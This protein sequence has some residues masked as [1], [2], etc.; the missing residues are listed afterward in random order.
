MT[1]D[2]QALVAIW[3]GAVALAA[4]ALAVTRPV[5]VHGLIWLIGALLALAAGF[6]SLGQ[7]FAGAVQILI[8]AGAVIAV[9]VFVVM[10]VD[11]DPET[12]ATERRRLAAAWRAPAALTAAAVLP[13]IALLAAADPSPAEGG[14]V[15]AKALGLLLFGPWAVAVEAASFLLLAALIGARLLARRPEG[16]A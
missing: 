14:A 8:Y 11:A 10:T 4:A 1:G 5:L 15:P 7:A 6:F 13:A 9:F 3:A 12:T 2:P 16:G